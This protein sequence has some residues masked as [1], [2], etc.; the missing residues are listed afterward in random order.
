VAEFGRVIGPP[1]ISAVWASDDSCL[2][3]SHASTATPAP[4]QISAIQKAQL[5][6]KAGDRARLL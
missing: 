2:S 6:G 3:F 4:A 5:S 1:M